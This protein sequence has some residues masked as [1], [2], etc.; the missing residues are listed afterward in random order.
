MVDQATTPQRQASG[1][2][3]DN[4]RRTSFGKEEPAIDTSAQNMA[5]ARAMF[6]AKTA[7]KEDPKAVKA[8]RSSSMAV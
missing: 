7:S 2:S 3:I 8:R 5:S 1:S 6:M 4:A